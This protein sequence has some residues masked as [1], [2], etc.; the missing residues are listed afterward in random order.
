MTKI[1]STNKQGN[2][3]MIYSAG[4]FVLDYLAFSFRTNQ[5]INSLAFSA[6]ETHYLYDDLAAVLLSFD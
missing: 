1:K 4:A 3:L 2:H 5:R 6:K